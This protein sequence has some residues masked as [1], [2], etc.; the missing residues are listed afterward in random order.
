VSKSA[1][2]SRTPSP[3][4]PA[5][6]SIKSQS[7]SKSEAGE[8]IMSVALFAYVVLLASSCCK[9][10]VHEDQ[11]VPIGIFQGQVLAA[12]ISRINSVD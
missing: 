3:G 7:N 12:T 10:S 9:L 6:L 2:Q 4:F 5:P 11:T 1:A 8:D